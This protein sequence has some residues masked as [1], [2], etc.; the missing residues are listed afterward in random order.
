MNQGNI[1]PEPK[2]E[3]KTRNNIKY[4]VN[5][6]INNVVYGK[7]INNQLLGLY[8]LILWKS[9][10]EEKSI[11]K[12]LAEIMHFQKL[13]NTFHKEYLEKLIATSLFLDFIL[14]IARLTVSKE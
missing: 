5:S 6:I 13:I 7:E 4:K 14:P 3:F 2:P 1:L 12:L 9:Y 8:Y 10:L 11:W